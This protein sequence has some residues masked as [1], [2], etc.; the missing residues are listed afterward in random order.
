MKQDIRLQHSRSEWDLGHEH[1]GYRAF[2]TTFW[3][4]ANCLQTQRH[5]HTSNLSSRM[6]VLLET[7]ES[8]GNSALKRRGRKTRLNPLKGSHSRY[9]RDVSDIRSIL[10]PWHGR[11]QAEEIRKT[12][13]STDYTKFSSV[14]T[15]GISLYS[16][17]SIRTFMLAS[18]HLD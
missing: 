10:G 8:A 15:I 1:W 7:R 11:L 2:S 9:T 6:R 5:Q 18:L 17:N 12:G 13:S 16:L 3:N 4:K 14:V